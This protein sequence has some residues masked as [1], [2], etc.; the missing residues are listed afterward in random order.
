MISV[1][2]PLYNKQLYIKR[3]IESIL[4]QT[5][6]RF[7]LIIIDDGST[8]ESPS[9]VSEINDPR[10]FYYLKKNGGESS[11]RNLG[12]IK[13]KYD[14]ICFLD[15]DDEWLPNHLETINSI[16]LRYKDCNAIATNYYNNFKNC[17][18]I[19]HSFKIK[20]FFVDNYFKLSIKRLPIMSSNTVAIN[21]K[22]I[23]T[24]GLFDEHLTHGP[25]L[26]YWFRIAL[27]YK[28]IFS[29]IPTAIY[30][31]DA[32]NRAMNNI[33]GFND[34]FIKKLINNIP[35][36]N[37]NPFV[38]KYIQGIFF[39]EIKEYLKIG[40][41]NLVREK[42]IEYKYQLKLGLKYWMYFILSFIPMKLI[43]RVRNNIKYRELYF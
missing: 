34:I 40:E 15:A 41:K 11:A 14:Y 10:I 26:D 32:E 35:D 30:H 3:A 37:S 25:D 20:E 13:A 5:F 29:S 27:N 36:F 7:E 22:I 6:E 33:I 42:L 12:I 24:I 16:I 4:N 21:K 31:H 1:V 43:V 18:K 2:I 8:D 23:E 28:I 19:A 9:I 39:G 17:N 38:F